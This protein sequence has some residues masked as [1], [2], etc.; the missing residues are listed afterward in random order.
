MEVVHPRCAGLDVS[1]RDAVN[2]R[3]KMH[4]YGHENCMNMAMENAHGKAHSVVKFGIR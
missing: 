1:K 3:D 4:E 2:G